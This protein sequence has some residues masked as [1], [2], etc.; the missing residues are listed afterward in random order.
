M[1]EFKIIG[2]GNVILYGNEYDSIENR[3]DQ[4]ILKLVDAAWADEVKRRE[5]TL[6]NGTLF[7][8]M[9]VNHQASGLFVEGNFISYKYFWAQRN[10]KG[11]DLN[12]TPLGVSGI[13]MT[14]EFG[15]EFV[16]FAKRTSVNL[17]YPGYYELIPSGGIDDRGKRGELNYFEQLIDELYEEVGVESNQV[18]TISTLGLLYDVQDK[19]YDIGCTIHLRSSQKEIEVCIKNS[20]EYEDVQFVRVDEIQNFLQNKKGN[21]VPAS[22]G[23]IEMLNT[24]KD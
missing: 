6:F 11:V 16:T 3:L 19:V 21:I 20:T 23:L 4:R 2:I 10:V 17:Q 22:I 7:N 1:A 5:K 8:C 14:E 18:K 13:L 12:I 24:N 9:R 15:H